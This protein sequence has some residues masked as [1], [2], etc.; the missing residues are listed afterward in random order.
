MCEDLLAQALGEIVEQLSELFQGA[1]F[2]GGGYEPAGA[3]A[4]TKSTAWPTVWIRAASSS[5]IFTP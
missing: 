3:W 5:V 4:T 2:V 1:A